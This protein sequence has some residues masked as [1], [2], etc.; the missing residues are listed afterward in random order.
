MEI[1]LERQGQFPGANLRKRPRNNWCY[2]WQMIRDLDWMIFINTGKNLLILLSIG[3]MRPVRITERELARELVFKVSQN[4]RIAELQKAIGIPRYAES[5]SPKKD[6]D[7]G[8]YH[9]ETHLE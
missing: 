2:C 4:G 7:F 3:Y 9:G 8:K 6:S 5:V 1:T